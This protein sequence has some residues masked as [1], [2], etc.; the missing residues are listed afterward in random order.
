MLQQNQNA[1][2]TSMPVTCHIQHQLYKQIKNCD[3]KNRF[4]TL[5]FFHIDFSLNPLYF[6]KYNIYCQFTSHSDIKKDKILMIHIVMYGRFYCPKTTKHFTE[7]HFN[8]FSKPSLIEIDKKQMF[9]RKNW[10]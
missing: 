3:D 1:A 5:P 6:T 8:F 4:H 7:H 2:N 10:L 9:I